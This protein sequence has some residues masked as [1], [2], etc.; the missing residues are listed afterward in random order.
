M[1]QPRLPIQPWTPT[2]TL[3]LLQPKTSRKHAGFEHGKLEVVLRLPGDQMTSLSER[4][5]S[6]L[7]ERYL[8]ERELGAGG[9]ATVYLAS[10]L[11]RGRSVA[12][13]VLRP[14]L[15]SLIGPERFLRE[16]EISGK[17]NPPHILPLCDSA[18][19]E[20]LP[21]FVMPFIE[22]ES[23]RDLL[24][25]EGQLAVEQALQIT[26]EVADALAYA[27]AQGVIPPHNNPG[28]NL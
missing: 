23:L 7:S 1:S 25:R 19:V 28:H 13:K 5:R 21:Y 24:V 20:G 14:E 6:G 15:A 8:I 18:Q 16:I 3:A 10:D 17:L 27:H 11:Q 12:L 9:M 26:R 2:A 4:F 22:G